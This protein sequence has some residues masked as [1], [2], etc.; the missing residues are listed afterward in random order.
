MTLPTFWAEV[1]PD[2]G[3]RCPG[4]L[5]STPLEQYEHDGRF[6]V[7]CAECGFEGTAGVSLIEGDA[8]AARAGL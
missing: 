3:R 6:A 8:P 4:A 1:F 7:R 5:R 2:H